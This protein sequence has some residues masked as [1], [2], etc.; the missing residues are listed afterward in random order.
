MRNLQNDTRRSRLSLQE[1]QER[2]G[3]IDK[4]CEIDVHFVMKRRQID[5]RRLG[6]I[7]HAL[8][9]SIEEHAIDVRAAGCDGLHEG[10][11]ARSVTDVVGDA[12]CFAEVV[13]GTHEG[14]DALLTAADGDDFAALADELGGHAEADAGGCADEE[15]AFG[16]EGGHDGLGLCGF[17]L[18]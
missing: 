14:C 9:A 1:R 3:D 7:V 11:E 13:V 12:V 4:T 10:R 18:I 6:E 2:R 8:H 16:G 15:D 17:G 5:R